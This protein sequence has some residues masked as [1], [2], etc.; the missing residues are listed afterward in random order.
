MI[1]AN[2]NLLENAV[3]CLESFCYLMT[4]HFF[5]IL[6]M[7]QTLFSSLKATLVRPKFM[8][9][10]QRGYRVRSAL[11]KRCE[12]CFFCRRKGVLRIVCKENPR[13]KQK[14]RS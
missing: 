5:C 1:P 13:H 4:F 9:P 14:Q 11:K 6:K 2:T 7:L 12:H 10:L 3:F 8:E